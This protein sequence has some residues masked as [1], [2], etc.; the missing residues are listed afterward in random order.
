[1][2]KRSFWGHKVRFCSLALGLWALNA[3]S[4]SRPAA[5]VM[6]FDRR[7]VFQK[8]YE[9]LPSVLLVAEDMGLVNND[10]VG[11]E[12]STFA[13]IKEIV[14]SDL[15]NSRSDRIQ[16]SEDQ[17]LFK[18]DPGQ[19]PRT[20]VTSSDPKDPIFI[21]LKVIND[22]GG[23]FKLEDAF[24][25]LIHE[26]GHKT[27]GKIQTVVDSVAA[28][29]ST[30]I[31]R[32]IVHQISESG[33]VLTAV[34]L[35]TMM[36][37]DGLAK[38][39]RSQNRISLF[40]MTT[41]LLY[42]G[43]HRV[44]DL[45]LEW[46]SFLKSRPGFKSLKPEIRENTELRIWAISFQKTV[47]GTGSETEFFSIDYMKSDVA[48]PTGLPG[49]RTS[50]SGNDSTEF[51]SVI[52][53]NAPDLRA[54]LAIDVKTGKLSSISPQQVLVPQPQLKAKIAHLQRK[55]HDRFQ[56]GIQIATPFDF[57][58]VKLLLEAEDGEFSVL[59]KTV[60]PGHDRILFD[61]TLPRSQ[62]EKK[63]IVR[64]LVVDGLFQVMFDEGITLQAPATAIKEGPLRLE[65]LRFGDGERS[66]LPSKIDPIDGKKA[67][68]TLVLESPLDI[69][70]IR[71]ETR[72]DRKVLFPKDYATK[73]NVGIY[74]IEEFESVRSDYQIRHLDRSEFTQARKGK[75]VEVTVPLND[76][77]RHFDAGDMVQGSRVPRNSVVAR[78]DGERAIT[79]LEI[80]DASLRSLKLGGEGQAFAYQLITPRTPVQRFEVAGRVKLSWLNSTRI[81][82][83]ALTLH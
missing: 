14:L 33:R 22:P 62:A 67:K 13:K 73:D 36:G 38:L 83:R 51:S 16:F 61:V 70:E 50:T 26:Y 5:V 7:A 40:S 31:V 58:R 29:I 3:F 2:K 8:A 47:G 20:A 6:D 69:Q 34:A 17:E 53:G 11:Q 82:R 71:F 52:R 27:S 35:P 48:S 74:T 15:V 59:A 18:L 12:F 49:V 10:F 54:E 37:A 42:Q 79:Q 72:R 39:I 66:V 56:I 60:W 77:V 45:T 4:Q 24:Q 43:D 78:D 44:S 41:A 55:D 32:H 19:P 28:K 21:N 65:S 64:S 23:T 1:M 68:F 57:R 75:F 63:F 80:V 46:E 25:I 76:E 9:L 81:C 30:Y